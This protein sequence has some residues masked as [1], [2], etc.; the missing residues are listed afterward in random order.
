MTTIILSTSMTNTKFWIPVWRILILST[1]VMKII[2]DYHSDK[3]KI[4]MGMKIQQ[5]ADTN[6]RRCHQVPEQR[7]VTTKCQNWWKQHRNTFLNAI[8]ALKDWWATK[9]VN[10]IQSCPSNRIHNCK[11]MRY[12]VDNQWVPLSINEWYNTREDTTTMKTIEHCRYMMNGGERWLERWRS[13]L[14]L[15]C[16]N[17]VSLCFFLLPTNGLG[18]FIHQCDR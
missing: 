1:N 9:T 8:F 18:I 16:E 6:V 4:Q 2:S 15:N 3:W 13:A 5:T 12:T 14:K 11:Q 10:L 17:N 7:I